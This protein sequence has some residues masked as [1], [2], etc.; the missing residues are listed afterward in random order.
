MGNCKSWCWQFNPAP[1]TRRPLSLELLV[2][3]GIAAEAS[4]AQ[5]AGGGHLTVCQLEPTHIEIG[6]LARGRGRLGDRD[7]VAAAA[8]C[9]GRQPIE[10]HLMR[11]A[12]PRV[13]VCFVRI[14]ADRATFYTHGIH[15]RAH[16]SIVAATA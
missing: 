3:V 10:R 2:R 4:M 1:R 9:V 8:G 12:T 6:R 15:E 5:A 16:G 11:S 13:E 14:A 7:R